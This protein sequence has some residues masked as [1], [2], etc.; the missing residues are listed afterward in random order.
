M[1]GKTGDKGTFHSGEKGTKKIG[2]DNVTVP[3]VYVLLYLAHR[4]MG[5]ST[6]A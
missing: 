5:L 6:L 2:V 4:L 3:F 1:I